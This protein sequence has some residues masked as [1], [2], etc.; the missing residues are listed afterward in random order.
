[1][2]DAEE[3]KDCN[4][5]PRQ[6]LEVGVVKLCVCIYIYIQIYI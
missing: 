3:E 4:E 1:M 5:A 2:E 6:L